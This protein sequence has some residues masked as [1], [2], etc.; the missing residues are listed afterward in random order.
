[1]KKKI[2]KAMTLLRAPTLSMKRYERLFLV[3]H[4]RGRTS[5]LSHLLGSNPEIAGYY[6]QHFKH[7]KPLSELR[8][9]SAL[10]AEHLINADT[11]YI[12]DKVLHN[13]IDPTPQTPAKIIVMLR[14]PAGAVA[15]IVKMGEKF[16]NYW[17]DE[18]QAFSY[19]SERLREIVFFTQ[20]TPNP[21]LLLDADALVTNTM[22]ALDTLSDFLALKQRLKPDYQTFEKTGKNLSGDSSQNIG[23]G[24]IIN[25]KAEV[26]TFQDMGALAQAREVYDDAIAKIKTSAN[27]MLLSEQ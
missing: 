3:S 5:L 24:K 10:M 16:Q 22:P 15:S 20:Q 27:T 21:V 13:R 23:T 7:K 19:Y 9:R 17:S 6:E 1:M 8:W 25:S 12:F 2:A 4:M 18:A 14:E 11:R 26:W